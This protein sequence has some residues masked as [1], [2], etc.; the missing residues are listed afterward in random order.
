MS[1]QMEQL[2]QSLATVFAQPIATY[3]PALGLV[4]PTIHPELAAKFVE[5]AISQTLKAVEGGMPLLGER[6]WG[7]VEGHILHFPAD[8]KPWRP[9]THFRATGSH[10]SL[11]LAHGLIGV[12]G[13]EA[14]TITIALSPTGIPVEHPTGT[15]K[16]EETG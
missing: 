7:R 2:I 16:E 15:G 13:E 6:D 3:H 5:Q 10:S 9:S 11:A 14:V 12:D 1:E 8:D 4:Y